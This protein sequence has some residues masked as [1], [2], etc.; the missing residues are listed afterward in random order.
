MNH[1]A[2]VLNFLFHYTLSRYFNSKGYWFSW[3]PY[4]LSTLPHKVHRP[5]IC[6]K[7]PVT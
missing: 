2:D 5:E 3:I 4:H 7:F 1:V 6:V